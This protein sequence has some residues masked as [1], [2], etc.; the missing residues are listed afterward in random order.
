MIKLI[1]PAHRRFL[2]TRSALASAAIAA[3]LL[4]CTT[5]PDSGEGAGAAEPRLMRQV[6]FP[7]PPAS[8]T[9]GERVFAGN[10]ISGSLQPSGDWRLRG[11][12][13][14]PRLRCGTYRMGLEF[15]TGGTACEAVDWQTRPQLL[16]ERVQ[17]NNATLI[18]SG[19]GKLSLP[20]QRVGAL[21]CVRVSLRC[22]GICG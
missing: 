19:G 6:T 5:S 22:G 3:M 10:G 16:R 7:L 12:V 9:N 18:H 17:C 8:G 2:A 15:G 11:E 20:P 21:N 4:G 13:T 1:G 14:H